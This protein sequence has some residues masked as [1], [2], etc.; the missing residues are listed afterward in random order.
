MQYFNLIA[1]KLVI[2]RTNHHRPYPRSLIGQAS[3]VLT[4]WF[5]TIPLPF[6][7]QCWIESKPSVYSVTLHRCSCSFL[8]F[9]LLALVRLL[10]IAEISNQGLETRSAEVWS[11]SLDC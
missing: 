7:T 9:F 3:S 8:F 2:E 1:D 5:W 6:S 4:R 10:L 11:A